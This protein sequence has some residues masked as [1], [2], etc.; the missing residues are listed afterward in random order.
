MCVTTFL[1]QF[2][3][4]PDVNHSN[5]Q[6]SMSMRIG[7]SGIGDADNT[8]HQIL[9][10]LATIENHLVETKK[11]KSPLVSIHRS[12]A[13]RSTITCKSICKGCRS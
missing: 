12:I 1:H 11:N 2:S 6:K 9:T 7:I 4:I 13:K 10:K 3:T 5:E 8:E